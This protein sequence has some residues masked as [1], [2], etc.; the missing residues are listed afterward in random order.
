LHVVNVP[1]MPYYTQFDRTLSAEIDATLCKNGEALVHDIASIVSPD[2]G[3]I[4]TRVVTGAAANIILSTAEEE[5]VDLIVIGARGTGPIEAVV[6]GSVSHRVVTHARCP[7]FMV[8][9]PVQSLRHV[10]L[11]VEGADDA[12]AARHFLATHP[13]KERVQVT[14]FTCP[15]INRPEWPIEIVSVEP[16]IQDAMG[17]AQVFVDGIASQLVDL[18]YEAHG[19]VTVGIP[20]LVITQ[21]AAEMNAD[22]ILMG[23]HGRHGLTRFLMGSVAH[24]VLHRSRCPVLVVRLGATSP[25]SR[26]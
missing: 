7:T 8:K 21:Q 14:V 2:A 17:A 11:A 9:R 10:F 12:E 26:T 19:R 4:Q 25:H 1:S 20:A 16:H 5:Q 13:F 15:P 23:S 24:A 6:F 22:I 18:G 3:K